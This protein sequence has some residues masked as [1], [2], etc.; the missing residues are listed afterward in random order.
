MTPSRDDD[1]LPA[2]PWLREALR[3]APDGDV[4]VPAAVRSAI[5]DHA[6]RAAAPAR[7]RQQRSWGHAVRQ[8]LTPTGVGWAGAAT[9]CVLVLVVTLV[10]REPASVDRIASQSPAR[11]TSPLPAAAESARGGVADTRGEGVHLAQATPSLTVKSPA[12]VQVPAPAAPGSDTLQPASRMAL[13][14][15]RRP[16]LPQ[17]RPALT[18]P[19]AAAPGSPAASPMAALASRAG[20]AAAAVPQAVVAASAPPTPA[21]E[22]AA[23]AP[24]LKPEPD[25][26]PGAVAQAASDT[27]RMASRAMN[28]ARPTPQAAAAAAAAAGS[29]PQ[30]GSALAEAAATR[31]VA[32]GLVPARAASPDR[33]GELLQW[34]QGRDGLRWSADGREG[35]WGPAQDAWL[36]ALR[37]AASGRW[38]EPPPP[39][40]VR[41]V[42]V[43]QAPGQPAVRLTIGD[44]P[45]A[46]WVQVEGAV[47][48]A[49][50]L[51]S[52]ARDRIESLR[53][54]W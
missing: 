32:A 25:A 23:A 26:P 11:T 40:E 54:G 24:A 17:S 31:P 37:A 7:A 35:T 8:L 6:R 18:A 36:R 45:W 29:Q 30:L 19:A 14:T 53:Q 43:L 38:G 21:P 42:V 9:A 50:R 47:P 13:D 52:R 39:P 2:D 5:L 16:D 33:L 3:H 27:V 34:T 20:E 48:V 41:G 49:T 44:A 15:A 51:D 10:Q 1:R 22:L 28:T 12:N 46:V 4:P